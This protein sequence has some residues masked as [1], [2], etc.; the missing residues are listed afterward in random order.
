M[1]FFAFTG[2]LL[3]SVF[4]V[5]VAAFKIAGGI[6]LVTAALRMLNPRRDEFS[7]E[8]LENAAVV[9]LAFPLTAGPGTITTVILLISEAS[10]ILAAF[11]VF[12]AILVG[13]VVC[14]SG[15]RYSPRI[16]KFLGIEGLR[17]ITKL[18][19][20]IVLAIAVQF[21]IG[22]ITEALPQILDV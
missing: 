8:E 6:L 13:I 15:M 9:P 7:K 2:E 1:A 10:N 20:I 19:S 11:L 3:F 12:V 16:F 4:N 5:T 17:V 18:M 14:Y 22:G 21:V